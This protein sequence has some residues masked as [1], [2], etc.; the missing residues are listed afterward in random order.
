M[1]RPCPKVIKMKKSE[2]HNLDESNAEK[3]IARIQQGESGGIIDNGIIK[4]RII[5]SL[6]TTH[7]YE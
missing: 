6:I 1:N 3:I 7:I 5:W 4:G 2:P